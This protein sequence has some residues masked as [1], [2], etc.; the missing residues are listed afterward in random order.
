MVTLNTSSTFYVNYRHIIF[1]AIYILESS[2]MLFDFVPD[3][4]KE[5]PTKTVLHMD[6]YS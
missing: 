3:E 6:I 1:S 4:R 2:S 5:L